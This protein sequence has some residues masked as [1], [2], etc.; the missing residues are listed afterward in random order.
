MLEYRENE[1]IIIFETQFSS[2]IV[3]DEY[4]AVPEEGGIGA[5]LKI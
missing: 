4:L 1:L 2:K 3:L 5:A